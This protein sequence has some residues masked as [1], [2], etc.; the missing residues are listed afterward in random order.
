MSQQFPALTICQPW[1]WAIMHG[2]KRVENRT[3]STQYR[4][5]LWIHAGKSTAWLYRGRNIITEIAPQLVLP[6]DRV[7]D[8]GAIVGSV[9]LYDVVGPLRG[10]KLAGEWA[11]GP[12]CWCVRDP[13]LLPEPI[14]CRGALG[15]FR[16]N[17]RLPKIQEQAI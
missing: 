7:F 9:E 2:A 15:L 4:G 10:I 3:W 11:S 5:R 17:V 6:D 1:A 8:F 12:H 13:I 14:P 16:P